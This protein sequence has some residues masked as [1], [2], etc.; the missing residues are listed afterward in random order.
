MQ[1]LKK[2]LEKCQ[3]PILYTDLNYEISNY[4]YKKIGYKEKK[5]LVLK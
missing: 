1:L 4:I 2:V 3:I 5:W